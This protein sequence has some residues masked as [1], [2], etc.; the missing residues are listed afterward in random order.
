MRFIAGGLMLVVLACA[1]TAARADDRLKIAIGQRG[2]FEN[3]ISE[4]GQD[5][6][7]FKKHGLTLDLLY[8]QGGGE[9]QQAVIAGS[10]DLGIG[11]GTDGAMGAF[12][13][14]A[15]VRILGATMHGYYEFWYVLSNSPLQSIKD[16]NGKSIAFSTNGSSSNIFVMAL[17]RQSGVTL[18]PIATGSPPQTFTQ[19]MTGQVDIGW[20]APPLM[21]DALEAGRIR[22]LVHGDAVPEF[23]DQPVRVILANA[24]ALEKN[25]DVFKRYMDAYRES[26]EW[27]W[28]SPD[29]MKAYA[30]WAQVSEEIAK[31]T[32]DDF[33]KKASADPDKMEGIAAMMDDAIKFKFL[34]APL[35]KAQLATLI[36]LQPR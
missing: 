1:A 25:P 7:I 24:G 20:T 4:L 5:A 2:A 6:G 34:S 8:T 22:V 9:T 27:L 30:K 31:R 15:P 14:G 33:V 3:G 36:Q 29:A 26:L 32:R 28:S 19:T 21:L 18:K 12:A 16:A 10:V 13:K 23:R 35:T 11:V 17:G